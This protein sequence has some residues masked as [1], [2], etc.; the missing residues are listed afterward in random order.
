MYQNYTR[1]A[2]QYAKNSGYYYNWK[3][4]WKNYVK[5]TGNINK[6]LEVLGIPKTVTRKTEVN[7]YYKNMARKHHPDFGGSV[8]KMK[9]INV[10]MGRIRQSPFYQKL[11]FLFEGKRLG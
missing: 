4:N 8:E 1:Q 9:D 7:S 2:G 10:A 11:A 3:N 5:G 6:D